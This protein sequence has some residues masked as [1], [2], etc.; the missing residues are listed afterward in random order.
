MVHPIK[1][2]IITS[3]CYTIRPPDF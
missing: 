3:A 1:S 2:L